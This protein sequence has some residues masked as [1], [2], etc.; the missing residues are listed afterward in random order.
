MLCEHYRYQMK[1][2]DSRDNNTS[3]LNIFDFFQV[4]CDT[5]VAI[6]DVVE[7]IFGNTIM[8]AAKSYA[9][10]GSDLGKDWIQNAH[11]VHR[12]PDHHH[13]VLT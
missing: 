2:H 3:Y 13:T 8:T 6:K 7:P 10:A 4:M 11:Q 9:N 12:R 5:A 1:N